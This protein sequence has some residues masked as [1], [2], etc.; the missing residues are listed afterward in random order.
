MNNIKIIDD[1]NNIGIYSCAQS[2]ISNAVLECQQKVFNKFGLAIQQDIVTFS[3]GEYLNYVVNTTDKEYVIFF[4]ID[5]IPLSANFYPIIKADMENGFLS[6]AIG[7]ANHLN[8]NEIYVHPCFMGFSMK[9]YNECGR[10]DLG[11]LFGD[12]DAGQKFTRH[13]T[14]LNKPIKYW[15]IT[16]GGDLTWPIAPR[17]MSFGHPTIFEN[18][19]YHQWHARVGIYQEMFIDKCH[20]LLQ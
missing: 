16:D 20:Q 2:N 11:S 10:P 1:V 18:M 12:Y 13:C 3:H 14:D 6:G 4:D 5:C 9:L 17:N 7:C 8:P 19:I 15:E